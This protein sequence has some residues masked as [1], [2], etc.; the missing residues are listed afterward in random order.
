MYIENHMV[1]N[2]HLAPWN[3]EEEYCSCERETFVCDY[4]GNRFDIEEKN[5]IVGKHGDYNICF[6]C[7]SSDNNE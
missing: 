4:C 5:T 1:L 2:M 7:F 6:D 3:Q